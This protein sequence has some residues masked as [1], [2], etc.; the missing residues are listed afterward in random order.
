MIQGLGGKFGKHFFKMGPPN[1]YEASYYY[2]PIFKTFKVNSSF[3]MYTKFIYQ[4]CFRDLHTVKVVS[5]KD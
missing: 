2:F 5:F 1:I 3:P 4:S